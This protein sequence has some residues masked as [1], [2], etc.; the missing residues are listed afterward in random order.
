M[1][2]WRIF[3]KFEASQTPITICCMGCDTLPSKFNFEK[4]APNDHFN[5]QR[6]VAPVWMGRIAL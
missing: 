4:S 1:A 6:A 2:V 3:F 5:L